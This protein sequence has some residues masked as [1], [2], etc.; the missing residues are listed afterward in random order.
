MSTEE[1]HLSLVARIARDNHWAADEIRRL[2][3]EH[4]VRLAVVVIV[5]VVG[6]VCGAVLS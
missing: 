2:R 5:F 4:D 1:Q 6:V 3:D